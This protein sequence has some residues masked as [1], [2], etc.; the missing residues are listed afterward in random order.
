MKDSMITHFLFQ[1][2][3]QLNKDTK[4]EIMSHLIDI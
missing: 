3:Q 4:K 1:I 2:N